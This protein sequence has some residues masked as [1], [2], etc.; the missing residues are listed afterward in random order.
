MQQT[1]NLPV[2]AICTLLIFIVSLTALLQLIKS[3]A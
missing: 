1:V 2:H 3:N